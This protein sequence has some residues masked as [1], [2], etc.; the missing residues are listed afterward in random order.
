M[1]RLLRRFPGRNSAR[2]NKAATP[3]LLLL[4]TV[5]VLVGRR[6]TRPRAGQQTAQKGV[7][8]P[9]RHQA[10]TRAIR[11]LHREPLR[12]PAGMA[13]RARNCNRACHKKEKSKQQ[14]SPN[15][16]LGSHTRRKSAPH[17]DWGS[18]GADAL[19]TSIRQVRSM[20]HD[21]SIP[22][23]DSSSKS[24]VLRTAGDGRPP[25]RRARLRKSECRLSSRCEKS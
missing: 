21:C 3:R 24:S 19:R 15:A 9:F 12:M 23:T 5:R 22:P 7:S 4:Q 2:A 17:I 6:R 25:L 8:P 20:T 10:E 11:T 14:I 16:H 1:S 18:R 13:T